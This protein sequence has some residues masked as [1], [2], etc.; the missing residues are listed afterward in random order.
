MSLD[1]NALK[2]KLN[3]LSKKNNISESVWRPPEG[4]TVIRIVPW[5]NNPTNPFTELY[6]HYIGNKTYLSPMSFGRR[7]PIAE[8]ADKLVDDARPHGREAEKE[9]WKQSRQ[10]VPKPRTYVPII[11]RGEEAKGVRFFSFGSTVFLELLSYI[12]DPDYGDIVDA[13]TGRDITIEYTPQG[14]SEAAKKFAKTD[15]KIKPNQTPLVP[16]PVLKE[17]LL[18]EQPDLFALYKESTYDE[19][20]GVLERYLNPE[21]APP[22]AKGDSAVFSVSTN[23]LGVKTE[24]SESAVVKNALD[25][26]DK[27]FDN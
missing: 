19:L 27:L 11:V 12:N 1:F 25:D 15:I 26:F 4:K 16:D 21:S 20:I 13:D 17:K 2:A 5:V 22:M 18:K 6:F 7:D 3:T 24:I 10:F 23:E 14:K 8:F 9:A